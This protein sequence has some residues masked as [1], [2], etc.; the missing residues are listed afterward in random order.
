MDWDERIR[1][2][3]QEYNIPLDYLADTL[4]EPKVVPMVRG[5]AFEFSAMLAL[6]SILD[7]NTWDVS[8]TPMNAQQGS[9]DVDVLVTHR[10]SSQRIAVECKLAKKGSFIARTDGSASIKVKC[11]R[12]RTL[13]TTMVAQLAP[14]LGV[15][16]AQLQVHNDQY[17]PT[18]FDVVITSIG[19]AFYDTDPTTGLFIWAPSP[20][21]VV[22]L[23]NLRERHRVP[24]TISLKDFAFSQ[25]Y[26]ARA[27]DL[28]V[29]ANGIQCGRRT[30]VDSGN[31]GFVPNYPII[32]FASNTL[33]VREP[34]HWAGNISH[35]LD[36]FI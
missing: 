18:D 30:C 28:A 33:T 8:K 12:S 2:Y 4:S 24:P 6:Q 5:K 26:V 22:F 15:A 23:E 32:N 10:A 31:C 34:W 19:N 11:M 14:Q 36:T 35:V 9:H 29:S 13:G 21:G 3:C 7:A 27:R 20:T 17:L 25:L 16:P 1:A